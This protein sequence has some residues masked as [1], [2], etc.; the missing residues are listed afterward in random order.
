MTYL[1]AV[2]G[3]FVTAVVMFAMVRVAYWYVNNRANVRQ[4][5]ARM[6]KGE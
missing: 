3:T 5:V 4:A 2:A 1:L 6:A